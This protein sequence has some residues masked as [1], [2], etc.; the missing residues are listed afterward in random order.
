[1][2]NK[3]LFRA[4]SIGDLMTESRSK[5]EKLS[6]TAKSYIQKVFKERE[7][8]YYENINS[9][10]IDKGIENEDEAIQLASEVLCWDFVIKNEEKYSNE[11]INGTPDVITKDLLA[12]IK[13]S[14]NMGTFPI[15]EDEIPTKNYWWQLQSYMW[16]TG[17]STS[18]L[19]YVLTNTPEQIVE[20]EIRRMHWKL[21]KIDEDLDLREAVQSQHTFDHIPNNL[22]IKRFIVERDEQAIEQ[23]KEKVEL[24][25][26]YY[27]QLKSIL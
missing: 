5:S 2:E 25:R 13:C 8:G 19:V 10:A 11:Y 14:W 3:I 21:N 26:N 23:I 17:H 18:E 22:R 6:K 16:L 7:F 12:D 24:C 27:E 9:K 4:S 20:D 15:F 1:M